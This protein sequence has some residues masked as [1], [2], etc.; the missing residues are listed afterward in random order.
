MSRPF[1]RFG[2]ERPT[3]R[4]CAGTARI[5][6]GRYLSRRFRHPRAQGARRNPPIQEST[7]RSMLRLSFSA[8]AGPSRAFQHVRRF[9]ATVRQSRSR[10]ASALRR[11][12][13]FAAGPPMAPRTEPG[14]VVPVLRTVES[15][16]RMTLP[17]HAGGRPPG[18]DDPDPSS[19]PGDPLRP[20]TPPE[21]VR[22]PTP[23]E[24]VRPPTPPE[25]L[26][27]PTPPEPARSPTPGEPIWTPP[28]DEGA[29]GPP[30]VFPWSRVAGS[31][32][33]AASAHCLRGTRR[34]V[35]HSR[36]F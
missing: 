28:T 7:R 6:A 20:P 4:W 16:M 15:A 24:P 8:T 9:R 31:C 32:P 29:G 5:T 33:N 34:P 19:P 25:P 36:P 2:L 17:R 14:A 35:R 1:A 13:S 27:P 3:M 21:P 11:A 26:R 30:V 10:R 18:P 23:P 12:H 22:P